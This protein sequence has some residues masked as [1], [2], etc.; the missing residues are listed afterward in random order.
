MD[1]R[2]VHLLEILLMWEEVRDIRSTLILGLSHAMFLCVSLATAFLIPSF[3]ALAT[4]WVEVALGV[5]SLIVGAF[6]LILR[7][8][9]WHVFLAPSFAATIIIPIGVALLVAT[10]LLVLVLVVI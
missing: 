1:F 3:L 8:I 4:L 2:L 6:L 7:S 9:L 10:F 5:S